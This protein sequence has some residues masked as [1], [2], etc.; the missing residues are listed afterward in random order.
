MQLQKATVKDISTLQTVCF[1]SYTQV[2]ASHWNENGLELYLEEQFG[3]ARLTIELQDTSV[4][5]YFVTYNNENIGFLKINYN[6]SSKLSKLDNCELEKIYIL[7]KFSGMGIGKKAMSEV[8]KK[9]VEKDKKLLFLC[10]ID[11][12]VDA[13]AFYKKL[14]FQF[15]S[16]TRLEITHFKEELK[17][18]E[19]MCFPLS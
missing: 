9:A 5:Y 11:T 16:K 4:E 8:I 1:D 13:I 2:F 18:M 14:G 12:N 15:H 6:S 7:P 10:V 3:N 19:R 17:G